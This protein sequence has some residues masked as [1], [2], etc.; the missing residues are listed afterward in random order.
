ML[1]EYKADHMARHVVY[2]A[3]ALNVIGRVAHHR[4]THIIEIDLRKRR[5]IN[6]FVH[7]QQNRRVLV[8]RA[9]KH[10]AVQRDGAILRNE[11]RCLVHLSDAAI[12][13]HETIWMALLQTV[14]DVIVE[15][16]NVGANLSK[17]TPSQFPI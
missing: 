10:N 14:H 12:D 13:A 1:T 16:W 2:P 5:T 9:P 17:K 6:G 7:L 11:F 4:F 8:G 3:P 15:R